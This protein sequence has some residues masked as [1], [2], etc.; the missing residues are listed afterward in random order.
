MNR[1]DQFLI[2]FNFRCLFLFNSQNIFL[3]IENKGRIT[4]QLVFI[5]SSA[6]S[7]GPVALWIKHWLYI[8][9][10]NFKSC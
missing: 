2:Y 9:K 10:D 3:C 8:L 5:I 1:L 6:G 7:R 4:L